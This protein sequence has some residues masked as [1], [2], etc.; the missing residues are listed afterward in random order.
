[1]LTVLWRV[2]LGALVLAT[3]SL[4]ADLDTGAQESAVELGGAY[5]ELDRQQQRLVDDWV[6]LSASTAFTSA[7][8]RESS[9]KASDVP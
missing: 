6:T 2:A 7:S 3:L 4:Y 1:M 9:E 5:L 8:V